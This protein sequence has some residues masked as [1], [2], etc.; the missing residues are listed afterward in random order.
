MN[1][2]AS[3]LWPH[4]HTIH[5][6]EEHRSPTSTILSWA[7]APFRLNHIPLQVCKNDERT[8]LTIETE[9]RRIVEACKTLAG[10]AQ[11]TFCLPADIPVKI[12]TEG[13]KSV[14]SMEL[15][16]WTFCDCEDEN[17]DQLHP[18]QQ[19]IFSCGRIFLLVRTTVL[20]FS[21]S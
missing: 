7:L 13:T 14:I 15:T 3:Y 10:L 11:R 5:L 18:E 17:I 2:L 21:F 16:N 19:E 12:E 1:S 20:F 8:L 4:T 6:C 9:Q